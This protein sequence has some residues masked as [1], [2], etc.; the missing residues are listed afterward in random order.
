MASI[1]RPQMRGLSLCGERCRGSPRSPSPAGESV[2]TV[3]QENARLCIQRDRGF[4]VG[5][6]MSW[7]CNLGQ[8]IQM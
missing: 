1:A 5:S 3:Q 4:R 7:L 6:A 2:C 8:D